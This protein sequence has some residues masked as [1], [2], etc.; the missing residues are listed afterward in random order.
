MEVPMNLTTDEFK[1]KITLPPQLGERAELREAM[2]EKTKED[3]VLRGLIYKIALENAEKRKEI[4]NYFKK[5]GLE[6]EYQALEDLANPEYGETWPLPTAEQYDAVSNIKDGESRVIVAVPGAGK[7]FSL[8]LAIE[9]LLSEGRYKPEEVT[10]ISFTTAAAKEMRDR[11]NTRNPNQHWDGIKVSTA[12]S[13]AY[14]ILRKYNPDL[15]IDLLTVAEQKSII[16]AEVAPFMN[17]SQ[18]SGNFFRASAIENN[19]LKAIQTA[20]QSPESAKELSLVAASCGLKTEELEGALKYY[21]KAKK[22]IGKM[23]FED[24][25]YKAIDLMKK[26][27]RVL[28]EV[29]KDT[30]VL[31]VDEYQDT[32]ILQRKFEDTIRPEGGIKMVVGD[33]D[34]AIFTSLGASVDLMIKDSQ[35]P[36]Y[37]V[38]V[39]SES[40]RQTKNLAIFGNAASHTIAGRIDKK[41][42]S[43]KNAKDGDKPT[44]ASFD[45]RDGEI[46]YI[47]SSIRN[48]IYSGENP[49][50]IA[51][52]C[53]LNAQVNEIYNAIQYDK[54]LSEYLATYKKSSGNM[55]FSNPFAKDFKTILSSI[56]APENPVAFNELLKEE[57]GS[58][59]AVDVNSKT[60]IDDFESF[61]K[62]RGYKQTKEDTFIRSYRYAL[63]KTT[64]YDALKSY[65][66]LNSYSSFN[67]EDEDTKAYLEELKWMDLSRQ[68]AGVRL[69]EL[70]LE[71]LKRE[72]LVV[73]DKPGI[74]VSTIH[75]SKG[76]EYDSVYIPFLSEKEYDRYKMTENIDLMVKQKNEARRVAYVAFTR[77]K[78]NEFISYSGKYGASILSV[79]P[80]STYNKMEN[81]QYVAQKE[82]VDLSKRVRRHISHSTTSVTNER[83]DALENAREF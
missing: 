12:H 28:A 58:L 62:S 57:F 11:I 46:K 70:E 72:N 68:E 8:V 22:K 39:L 54:T 53:R 34:Q 59:Y 49:A 64:A 65:L 47:L 6:R 32:S 31:I 63:E 48:R 40:R 18:D 67:T 35:N 74:V 36:N 13:L 23:D 52:L 30:K 26:K 78:K 41:Y 2:Y 9:N 38:K 14:G 16:Q 33:D 4:E 61:I 45:S 17:F 29:Q 50:S 15:K 82:E 43:M 1:K 71:T 37:T 21:E 7:T 44:I 20:R 80:P 69:S 56:A 5:N 10:M 76:L 81:G 42:D 79:L 51:V 73:V 19:L 25:I 3:P 60:P 75:K 55:L 83:K 77:A 24:L 66:N 27:P